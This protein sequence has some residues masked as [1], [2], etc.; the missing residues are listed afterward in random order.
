MP[1]TFQLVSEHLIFVDGLRWD[2]N[3]LLFSDLWGNTVYALSGGDCTEIARI[4]GRPS[5]LCLMRD[6]T[7]VV[8]SMTERKLFR[9]GESGELTEYADLSA[10]V[11]APLNEAIVDDAGRIYVGHWGFDVLAGEAPR[12]ASLIV[13]SPNGESREVAREMHFPNGMV[14]APDGSTLFVAETF[15]N[16]I[17]AF[18]RSGDGSLGDRRVW[19]ELGERTP[20]GL[21]M[22]PDGSVWAASFTTGE[23][24]RISPEGSV[25]DVIAAPAKRA[26]S[27]CVGGTDGTRLFCSSFDGEMEDIVA[28]RRLGR[29]DVLEL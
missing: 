6:G 26:I 25:Q 8:V 10:L 5:G 12:E 4:D 2:D 17:S 24:L 11:S 23:F 21:A 14:L 1:Q 19:A 28:K 27:C 18:S 22:A 20:D 9:I 3:R 13:V 15:A 29:I 7:L 16:R